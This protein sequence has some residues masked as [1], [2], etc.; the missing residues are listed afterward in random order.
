[1]RTIPIFFI[2]AVL[3]AASVLTAVFDVPPDV[4]ATSTAGQQVTARGSFSPDWAFIKNSLS[5]SG[6]TNPSF[7]S[8]T[9]TMQ[10]TFNTSGGT[11]TGSGTLAWTG[12]G[13]GTNYTW[14]GNGERLYTFTGTYYP[15][16]AYMEGTCTVSVTDSVTVHFSDGDDSNTWTDAGTLTWTAQV[17]ASG[18]IDG[19]LQGDLDMPFTAQFTPQPLTVTSDMAGVVTDG[20]SS[21]TITV[22]LPTAADVTVTL[23]DGAAAMSTAATNGMATFSYVPDLEQLGIPLADIPAAGREISLTAATP[24]GATGNVSLRLF[25]PPVLLVHGLWSDSHMWDKMVQR[26]TA[27]NFAVYTVDY[28]NVDSP[29]RV[30]VM[31]FASKVQAVRQEYLQQNVNA[32]S[33][34]VIGHSMGGVVARHYINQYQGSSEVDVNTLITVGT[35]HKGS[36]WPQIYYDWVNARSKLE[37]GLLLAQHYLPKGSMGKMGPAL[38]AL[39]PDSSFLQQ[40]NSQPLNPHV[41]YIAV[42]GTYN[43]LSNICMLDIYDNMDDYEKWLAGVQPTGLDQLVQDMVAGSGRTIQGDGVV[44]LSSQ[45]F[46]EQISEGYYVNAWHCGEGGNRGVYEIASAVL[47]GRKQTISPAYRQ[48]SLPSI[49][50]SYFYKTSETFELTRR[51]YIQGITDDSLA[52]GDTVEPGDSIDIVYGS[53]TI[54]KDEYAW[55]KLQVADRGATIG[56]LFVRLGFPDDDYVRLKPLVRIDILSPHSF[57]VH[58]PYE[59]DVQARVSYGGAMSVLTDNG[60]FTSP[61]P[62]L[63]LSLDDANNTQMALLDGE[64]TA[65]D[66]YN[67]SAALQPGQMVELTQDSPMQ[68][69]TGLA[70][71]EMA[72]WWAAD[73]REHVLCTSVDVEGRPT[74]PTASFTVGDAAHS[75]LRLENVSYGDVVTWRFTGPGN[76][77]H[78]ASYTA[79]WTG[80]GWCYSW[81]NLSDY[82]S[83][84]VGDWTVDVMMN[85]EPMATAGFTVAERSP[86]PA[87]ELLLTLLAMMA[88]ALLLEKRSR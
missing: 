60:L 16:Q 64:V 66:M 69:P 88:L 87:F 20:S 80:E 54:R 57:H 33:V 52:P 82:G 5:S 29:A 10:L 44:E 32:S 50:V 53:Y 35:P 47:S 14:N 48:P 6:L 83:N 70:T 46:A 12:S 7:S 19:G 2:V 77:S 68:P 51:G 49:T 73:L 42:C 59:G 65:Y 25:R 41:D 86:T 72:R 75:L 18:A 23:S 61:D 34:D 4:A 1:M 45:R 26:L 71:S 76:L 11:V 36:P 56:T 17:D 67:G 22:T 55:V 85:R 39:M 27:D 28:P 58:N 3:V 43:L 15:A 38:S 40:L 74:G 78:M 79:D 62:D 13:T 31:E 9:A 30:A 24:G 63:V 84:A 81:V 21:A 37:M 8:T